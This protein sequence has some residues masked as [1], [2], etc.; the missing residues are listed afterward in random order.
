MESG[1]MGAVSGSSSV[2]A[3][4][5]ERMRRKSEQRESGGLFEKKKKRPAANPASVSGPPGGAPT[6]PT[7]GQRPRAPQP[8][9]LDRQPRERRRSTAQSRARCCSA[10]LSAG[11]RPSFSSRESAPLASGGGSNAGRA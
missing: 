4:A 5:N 10:L 2:E 1:W 7:D 3:T 11:R 9:R 6:T 8:P